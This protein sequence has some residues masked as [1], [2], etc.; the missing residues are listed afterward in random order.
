MTI[1]CEKVLTLNLIAA[2]G[3]DMSDA[4]RNITEQTTCHILP[5]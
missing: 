4:K 5:Q 1:H 3:R 2:L